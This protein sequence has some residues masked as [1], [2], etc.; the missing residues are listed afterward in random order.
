MGM[1]PETISE[2]F[3][4]EAYWNEVGS[5]FDNSKEEQHRLKDT[6]DLTPVVFDSYFEDNQDLCES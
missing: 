2:H 6:E 5:R 1:Q 3:I 4:Q